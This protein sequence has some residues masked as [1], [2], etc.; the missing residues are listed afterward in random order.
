M[1]RAERVADAV[2]SVPASGDARM[3]ARPPRVIRPAAPVERAGGE[4]E[5]EQPRRIG[6]GEGERLVFPAEKPKRP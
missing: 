4:F 5:R 1:R 2:A 6:A 3:R